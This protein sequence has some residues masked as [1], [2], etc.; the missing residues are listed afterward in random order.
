M[1]STR[2]DLPFEKIEI[3]IPRTYDLIMDRVLEAIK[4]DAIHVGDS[5]PPER[6]L[7]D[8]LGISRNTLREGLAI[9][10]VTKR[11]NKRRFLMKS[12]EK[13]EKILE[14]A[15]TNRLN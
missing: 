10:G 8:E 5:L 15:R 7:A 13:Y 6:R 12:A 14:Q 9:L 2:E 4:K 1:F 11:K 3:I